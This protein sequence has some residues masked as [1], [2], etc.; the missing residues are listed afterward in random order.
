MCQILC[1]V[2]IIFS[3]YAI[4]YI[5]QLLVSVDHYREELVIR[6]TDVLRKEQYY[7]GDHVMRAS[8]AQVH[9][10]LNVS[11]QL[12]QKESRVILDMLD[13]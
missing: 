7:E 13:D 3:V 11:Q 8:I 6:N 10:Y 2:S 5:V 1:S 9:F 12:I 4:A